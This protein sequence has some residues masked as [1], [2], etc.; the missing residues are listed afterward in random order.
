MLC[1]YLSP[2]LQLL[3]EFISAASVKKKK[4]AWCRESC[5]GYLNS[6]KFIP[7]CSHSDLV[8]AKIRPYI[9]SV[10][11]TLKITTTLNHSVTKMLLSRSLSSIHYGIKCALNTTCK[12]ME[13]THKYLKQWN[14]TLDKTLML[15]YF[16]TEALP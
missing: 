10:G 2:G 8:S 4:A 7:G 3:F 16:S 14:F 11:S 1:T 12:Y 6:G 9:F 13:V 15:N 5:K